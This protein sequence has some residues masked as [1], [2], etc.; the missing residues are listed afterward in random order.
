MICDREADEPARETVDDR[1]CV[2]VVNAAGAGVAGDLFDPVLQGV[3][4]DAEFGG[5]G[6]VGSFADDDRCPGGGKQGVQAVADTAR[7]TVTRD[8]G[9][10][11]QQGPGS[12]HRGRSRQVRRRRAMMACGGCVFLV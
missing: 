11:V 1:G 9:E 4:V 5:D 12:Q 2:R 6:D 8:V 7:L 3:A 10:Q